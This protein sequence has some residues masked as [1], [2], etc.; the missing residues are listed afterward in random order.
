MPFQTCIY[1]MIKMHSALSQNIYFKEATGA[2]SVDNFTHYKDTP[3]TSWRQYIW[4]SMKSSGQCGNCICMYCYIS[5]CNISSWFRADFII[6]ILNMYF[7]IYFNERTHDS[8]R[9]WFFTVSHSCCVLSCLRIPP[10]FCDVRCCRSET[11]YGRRRS[12]LAYG[13]NAAC[14]IHHSGPCQ[15]TGLKI[16][17]KNWKQ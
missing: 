7:Y 14:W 3:A 6:H 15:V 2:N 13:T 5:Y 4:K 17:W 10:L 1:C 12:G 11:A 16:R 8:H 9:K